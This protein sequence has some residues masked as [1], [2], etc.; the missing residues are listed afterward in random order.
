MPPLVSRRLRATLIVLIALVATPP[1]I[2]RRAAAST[3]RKYFIAADEVAW[4]YAPA[5]R[6][7]VTGAPFE[8]GR[9]HV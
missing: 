6:N 1:V 5:G 9:A 7:L 4:N 3:V 2:S 8:I